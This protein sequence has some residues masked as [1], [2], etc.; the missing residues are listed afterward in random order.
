ML[1]H[2][3]AQAREKRG[4]HY[5]HLSCGSSHVTASRILLSERFDVSIHRPRD[6]S[7]YATS[8]TPRCIRMR[9]A[10]RSG[11]LFVGTGIIQEQRIV[12]LF[13]GV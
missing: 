13:F 2:G 4:D 7:S 12:R 8:V 6:S 3:A 11:S 9:R 1:T 10:L 5:N